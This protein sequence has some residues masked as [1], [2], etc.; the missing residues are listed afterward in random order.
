MAFSFENGTAEESE[1]ETTVAD[2]PVVRRRGRPPGSKNKQRE[3]SQE[4]NNSAP[5]ENPKRR[6]RKP[7]AADIEA[8]AQRLVAM[9][10]MLAGFTGTPE[11]Q[12]SE[13]EAKMLAE[14]G[15]Q[16]QREF[17]VEIGGKWAMLA[18]FVG[19][20]GMVYVPRFSLMR[21]RAVAKKR[22]GINP[23]NVDAKTQEQNSAPT[24]DGNFENVTRFDA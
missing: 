10:A 8:M 12:L 11:F 21:A 22:Q 6:K 4:T 9:H 1:T 13:I 14:S 2:E 20:C 23:Q 3:A 18:T 5:V 7:K 19:V 24:I 15:L 17:D 16:V